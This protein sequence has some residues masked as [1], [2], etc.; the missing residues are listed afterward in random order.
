MQQTWKSKTVGSG[1]EPGELSVAEAYRW[2]LVANAS[3]GAGGVA[4]GAS[5][6]VST[7]GADAALGLEV[8]DPAA[9]AASAVADAEVSGSSWSRSAV[10]GARLRR[11]TSVPEPGLVARLRAR[12]LRLAGPVVSVGT[13][14]VVLPA[15]RVLAT[16][17]NGP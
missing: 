17:L 10:A 11:L 13:A 6:A 1:N 15:L 9:V 7:G 3:G 5:D 14:V 12:S 16:R 8:D 2:E 4:D